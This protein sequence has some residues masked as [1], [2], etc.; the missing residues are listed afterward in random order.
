MYFTYF[1]R[2]PFVLLINPKPWFGHRNNTGWRAKHTV[3]WWSDYGQ[4][5][6]CG[7]DLLNTQLVTTFHS[8]LQHALNL[9]SLLRLH[10]SLP[11]N[12]FNGG[13][14]PYSGF[15]NYPRAS[16]LVSNSSK[17]PNCSS[18]L[19][20]HQPTRFVPLYSS[21]L[22]SLTSCSAYNI[23]ARTAQKTLFLCCCSIVAY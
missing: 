10:Q 15:P 13:L 20:S 1:P 22:T 7:L 4:C 21:A 5:F 3:T 8:S 16:L 6:S 18:P 17:R 19:T 9:C 2:S 12:G 14:S 11:G 23:S